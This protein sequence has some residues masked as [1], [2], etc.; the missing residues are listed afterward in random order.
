MV[1][2]KIFPPRRKEV[3]ECWRRLDNEELRNFC[4]SPDIGRMMKSRIVK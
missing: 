3:M 4:F 2:K 1:L